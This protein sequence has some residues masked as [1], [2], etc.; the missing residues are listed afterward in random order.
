M[1]PQFDVVITGDARKVL[2]HLREQ[3]EAPDVEIVGQVHGKHGCVRLPENRRSILSPHLEIELRETEAGTV[4]HGR[5]SPRPNVW[6]GFMA[7]YFFIG[8]LGLTGLMYGLAQM[9]VGG[10][11]WMIW[12][13]P[14][15][16]ALIAFIY[17]AAFIGQGLSTEEMFE[18]RAFV[19]CA[20]REVSGAD[21]GGA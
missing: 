1:R 9:M 16:V 5:F 11:I 3:L 17:G 18:L 19:E 6:T 12:A 10:P 7:L 21:G 15:S 2:S 4:L 14:A 8:M 20:V 13:A